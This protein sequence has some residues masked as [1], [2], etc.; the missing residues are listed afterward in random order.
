M[1]IIKLHN[2]DGANLKLVNYDDYLWKFEVDDKHK[3]ILQ[4]MRMGFLEDN[5]TIYF[6]DPSGGP[7]LS[8]GKRLNKKYIINAIFEHENEIRFQLAENIV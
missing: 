4:Y 8:R 6:V 7:Y 2:R 5:K 1:N 3:Y